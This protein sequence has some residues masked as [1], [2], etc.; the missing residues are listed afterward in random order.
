[1]GQFRSRGRFF[2]DDY[3]RLVLSGGGRDGE[4]DLH[5]SKEN[6]FGFHIRTR[7]VVVL[8]ACLNQLRGGL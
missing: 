8:T 3:D 5:I 4:M 2:P 6:L 7:P 1:V